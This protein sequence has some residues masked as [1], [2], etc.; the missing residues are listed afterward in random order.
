[1][2]RAA[3]S[4]DGAL[5]VLFAGLLLCFV[6]GI[7]ALSRIW[8][9]VEYQ[10]HG[11]LV[12]IVA[13]FLALRERARFAAVPRQ[14]SGVGLAGLL[15][16]LALYAVASMG[17]WATLQGVAMVG[18]VAA[19][20]LWLRGPAAL[21]A[22]A[23]PVAYLLFMVPLPEP[24]VAPT[25]V[26][27]RL[28]VT[29][30]AVSLLHGLGIPVLREGNSILLPGGESLFVADACS[31]VTSLLTLLPLAVLVA[32]LTERDGW[33][34]AVLIASVVPIALGFNLF[35][36]LATVLAAQQIG[37]ER[38]TAGA[39]HEA[40]GLLVYAAGCVALLAVGGLL[41]RLRPTT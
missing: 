34:R 4:G 16:A 1:M 11:Y 30:A 14:R 5:L 8:G 31:G 33:R 2:R 36:V 28:F 32:F 35:R 15:V 13:L 27:L 26:R 38:A 39:L 17:G 23:F 12:P 18:S 24:W 29:T 21:R 3:R 19:S 10:S 37:V 7:V 6:P 40:A 41:R 9:S 25:I 20:L 22:M